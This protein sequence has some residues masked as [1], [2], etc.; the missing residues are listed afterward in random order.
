MPRIN[1]FDVLWSVH[2]YYTLE[3]DQEV[4]T[5]VLYP[6]GRG[7]LVSTR[8][9]C[10]PHLQQ[11]SVAHVDYN[12]PV[13]Q[14]VSPRLVYKFNRFSGCTCTRGVY[15]KRKEASGGENCCLQLQTTRHVADAFP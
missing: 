15:K 12:L 3:V 6:R 1:T 9:L 4:S 7:R 14:V 10:T 5:R 13:E 11:V 2:V 8:I